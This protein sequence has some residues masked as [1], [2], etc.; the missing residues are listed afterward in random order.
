MWQANL[1]RGPRPPPSDPSLLP[2][3]KKTKVVHKAD[4]SSSDESLSSDQAWSSVAS[5]DETILDQSDSDWDDFIVED[6]AISDE[7][8]A[9]ED[10]NDEDHHS[11]L[12]FQEKGEEEESNGSESSSSLVRRQKRPRDSS[13]SDGSGTDSN[14]GTSKLIP[15]PS[16]AAEKYASYARSSRH[17]SRK[18]K[19]IHEDEVSTASTKDSEKDMDAMVKKIIQL[20]SVEQSDRDSSRKVS[21]VET[22]EYESDTS[23]STL[24]DDSLL[25]KD[26][27]EKTDPN[28]S[29]EDRKQKAVSDVDKVDDQLVEHTLE[30]YMAS[31]KLPYVT[32]TFSKM[33]NLSI[34]DLFLSL[35][36]VNSDDL[37]K[38]E[39]ELL[40]E[41][42]PI[43]SQLSEDKDITEMVEDDEQQ[44]GLI[45]GLQVVRNL[46]S[47]RVRRKKSTSINKK[48]NGLLKNRRILLSD[49]ERTDSDELTSSTTDTPLVSKKGFRKIRD[50]SET[51]SSMRKH[52]QQMWKEIE[53]RAEM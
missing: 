11:Y 23:I 27:N 16:A 49:D 40:D 6:D 53:A 46:L 15:K 17:R 1:L 4:E 18:V 37:S 50:D 8:A 51:V 7:G 14:R 44:L 22:S 36:I 25:E 41:L 12:S 34:L 35:N 13:D 19:H 33:S 20:K 43:F 30:K 9:V 31:Q 24:S 52:H 10:H 39:Q 28:A 2:P 47:D 26:E 29:G 45:N 21:E 32:N 48:S 42:K 3:N 38:D 5:D